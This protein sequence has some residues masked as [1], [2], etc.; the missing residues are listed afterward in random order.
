MLIL[1]SKKVCCKRFTKHNY[2]WLN[3]LHIYCFHSQGFVSSQFLHSC[4]PHILNRPTVLLKSGSIW[5]QHWSILCGEI[6]EKI[7]KGVTYD[8]LK[9]DQPAHWKKYVNI[10]ASLGRTV[11][12]YIHPWAVVYV[13]PRD[14]SYPFTCVVVCSCTTEDVHRWCGRNVWRE[15]WT[16]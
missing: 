6:S 10:S 12:V 7:K 8:W 11:F 1:I 4:L 3:V 2:I 5:Y 15:T 13:F 16:T 9:N 14:Y